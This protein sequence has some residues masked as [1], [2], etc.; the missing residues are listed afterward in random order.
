[1]ASSKSLFKK[2]ASFF[3]RGVWG[4]VHIFGQEDWG[5]KGV[6]NPLVSGAKTPNHSHTSHQLGEKS[7]QR[8][9][10]PHAGLVLV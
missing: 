3:I 1:M 10:P 9:S 4:R 2:G 7:R 5:L 6:G 8:R